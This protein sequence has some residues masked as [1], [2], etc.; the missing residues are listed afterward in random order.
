MKLSYLTVG[1]CSLVIGMLFSPLERKTVL[2]APESPHFQ[3]HDATIDESDGEAGTVPTHEVFL[4]NTE[5]GEVWKFQSL[6]WGK[7]KD[8]SLRLFS[9]PRF[10]PIPVGPIPVGLRK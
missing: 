5:S 6:Q 9:E 3:L 4:L 10:F 1:A 2:A 8:G 7:N